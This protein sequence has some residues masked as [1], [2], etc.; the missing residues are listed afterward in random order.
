MVINIGSILGNISMIKI[1][2]GDIKNSLFGADGIS[3]SIKN[4]TLMPII[5]DADNDWGNHGP[6]GHE[7]SL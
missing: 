2:Q 1:I 3:P 6:M 5:D 7:N 4:G